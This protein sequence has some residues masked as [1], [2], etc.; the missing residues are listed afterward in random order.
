MFMR[1]CLFLTLTSLVALPLPARAG[2]DAAGSEPAL[3]I[4]L[5]AIEGLVADAKHLATL[6]GKQEEAGQFEAIFKSQVNNGTLHGIDVTRPLGAYGIISPNV[7][8]STAVILVPVGNPQTIL[9]FVKNFGVDARKGDD[10]VYTIQMPQ[11][12]VPLFIRFAND[13]AYVTARDK[14]GIAKDKL[15]PPAKVLPPEQADTVFAGFRL[16]QVPDFVKNLLIGQVEVKLAELQEKKTPGESEAQQALKVQLTKEIAKQFATFL[17]EGGAVAYRVN[18][19]RK[20]NKLAQE[21]TVT[22]VAKSKLAT[23]IADLSQSK[24]RFGSL[25]RPDAALNLLV[26]MALPEDVREAVLKAATEGIR[27]GIEKETDATKQRHAKA[28]FSL[29][30][31]SLKAGVFDG[32]ASFRASTGGKRYSFVAGL[33]VPN[34]GEIEKTMRELAKEIPPAERGKL[35]L[36]AASAGAVAIH[37]IDAKP[38]ENMLAAVGDGPM[39]FAIAPDAVFFAAGPEAVQAVKESVAAQPKAGSQ[40]SLDLSFAQLAPLMALDKKQKGDPVAASLKAF[41]GANKANDKLRVVVEGGKSL[42][43]RSEMDGPVITFF[44]LVEQQKK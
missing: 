24:S 1:L 19:D 30:E 40:V 7:Q 32:F 25:A 35:Q 10:D 29:L 39:Y 21:L 12:P 16:D 37:R 41:T 5:R 27:K 34:G 43:I 17:N 18:V 42:R 4:R 26:H 2:A 3:L 14:A 31:P 33:K 11:L 8:D 38:D 9:D 13:Y 28:L 23:T 6:V 20:A 15:L 22:P 44:N 36:N